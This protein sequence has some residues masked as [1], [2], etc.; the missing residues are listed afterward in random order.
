[1]PP[2]EQ[3]AD[4]FEQSFADGSVALIPFERGSAILAGL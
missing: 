3:L 2:L 1:M 4:L